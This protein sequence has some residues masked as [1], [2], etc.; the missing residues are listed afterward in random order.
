MPYLALYIM[1]LSARVSHKVN[2]KDPF[3]GKKP[4]NFEAIFLKQK[5][6]VQPEN[7]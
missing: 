3:R 6:A 1:K 5:R 7:F 2:T 4:K